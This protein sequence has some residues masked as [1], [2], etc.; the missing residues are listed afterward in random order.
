MILSFGIKIFSVQHFDNSI[1]EVFVMNTTLMLTSDGF[2]FHT[3]ELKYFPT[4]TE[5]HSRKKYL[6]DLAREEHKN[7]MYPISYENQETHCCKFFKKQ[8]TNLYFSVAKG[9]HATIK[10]V[11]NPRKLI[12]PESSYLGIFPSNEDSVSEFA[13]SFTDNMRKIDLPDFSDG[14]LATRVDLCVNLDCGEG[15]TARELNRLAHKGLTPKKYTRIEYTSD[16]LTPEKLKEKNKHYLRYECGSAALV[17]YDKTY[18][19]TEEGLVTKFEELP[20]GIIRVELQLGRKFI[21]KFM[22]KNGIQQED[23]DTEKFEDLEALFNELIRQ[24]PNLTLSY[25]QK[26]VPCGTHYKLSRLKYLLDKLPFHAETIEQMQYLVQQSHICDTLN[27]A[28]R[29]TKKKFKLSEKEVKSLIK[30]FRDSDISPI[31]LSG[32]FVL[33]SLPSLTSLLKQLAMEGCTEIDL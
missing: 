19:M 11:V 16:S 6:Y 18:Q 25:L 3:T 4:M 9:P 1:I 24:S 10:A 5:Y 26:V 17:I 2:S 7:F 14:W 13:D 29:K 28:I 20:N 8:G 12:D 27:D 31:P 22:E 32:N 33:D 23:L 30:R 21:R 15:N